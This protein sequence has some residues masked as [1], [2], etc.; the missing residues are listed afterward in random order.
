[1]AEYNYLASDHAGATQYGTVTA[2]TS[3]EAAELVRNR[4]LVVIRLSAAGARPGGAALALFGSKK[5]S[6]S[7]KP[8]QPAA[9]VGSTPATCLSLPRSWG[10]C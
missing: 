6:A 9:G 8:E 7:G 1:M 4:G 2:A 3:H 10:P 5:A